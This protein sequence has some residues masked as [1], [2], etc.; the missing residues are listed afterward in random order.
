MPK[1]VSRRAA[2]LGAACLAMATSAQAQD[3]YPSRP[4]KIV[5]PFAA[6]G[7]VDTVARLLAEELR[8]SL[9]QAIVVENAAGASGMRGAEMAVRAEPDGYTLLL[10][11]AGE[12]AVNPH[13]F[14][15]MRY[16]AQRDLSPISLVVKVP[17]VLVVGAA[18]PYKTLDDFL[19]DG[20]IG[21]KISYS[22]SGI[23]NPQHLAGELMNRMAKGQMTH[24][25]YRGAA[26]QVQDVIGGSVAGTFASY[27]AVASFV[28]N[29]QVRALGVTSAERIPSLKDVPAIGEHPELKGFEVTNWFG[30]F[31]PAKTPPA[32]IARVNAAVAK[33]LAAATIADK[34]QTLGSYPSPN[35]P[36]AFRAFLAAE[37]AKFKEIV[38]AAGVTLQ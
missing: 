36:E 16:D 18:T 32:V 12:T 23:G 30:L 37:T 26:Q 35:S 33:A 27:L 5:V 8:V 15:D 7:G 10:A 34:L 19:K 29:G 9:G 20:R 21:G 24:V 31:A 25:P 6:G 1:V 4:I 13:L 28:Q 11:S 17:N 2:M 38:A 22:S 3:A 14:K